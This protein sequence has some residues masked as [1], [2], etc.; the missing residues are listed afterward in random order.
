MYDYITRKYGEENIAA[1]VVHLDESLPHI[2]CTLVP[3][4]KSVNRSDRDIFIGKGLNEYIQQ[5]KQLHNEL[6]KV[7]ETK[8]GIIERP[9]MHTLQFQ[10]LLS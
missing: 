3:I 7:N 8:Q 5:T 9:N 10:R 2:H 1:F 6:A 4:T